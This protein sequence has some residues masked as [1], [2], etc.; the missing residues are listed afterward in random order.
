MAKRA[1]EKFLARKKYFSQNFRKT[2]AEKSSRRHVVFRHGNL[3]FAGGRKAV[4][5]VAAACYVS[6]QKAK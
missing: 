2:V 3:I 5:R 1:V 4:A 6:E